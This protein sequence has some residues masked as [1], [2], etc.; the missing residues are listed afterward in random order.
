MIKAL[1]ES[2]IWFIEPHCDHDAGIC[3]KGQGKECKFKG[4]KK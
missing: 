2:L 3:L 4:D 1:W